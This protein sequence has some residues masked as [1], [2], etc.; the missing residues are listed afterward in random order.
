MLDVLYRCKKYDYVQVFGICNNQIVRARWLPN[1]LLIECDGQ[2]GRP[3]AMKKV[4]CEKINTD[5]I[6]NTNR[7]YVSYC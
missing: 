6:G 3:T 5:G 7:A 2:T 4:L 1:Q